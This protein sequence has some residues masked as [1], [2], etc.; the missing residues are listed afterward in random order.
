MRIAKKSGMGRFAVEVE[1]TNNR[2]LDNAK[3]GYIALSEVR[4]M[5][6]SGVVDSGATRLVIP[7]KIARQL[8]LELA[9]TAKVRYADERCAHRTGI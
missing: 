2:D 4:R 9:G 3:T 6:V 5:R 1:L 8:G 7:G